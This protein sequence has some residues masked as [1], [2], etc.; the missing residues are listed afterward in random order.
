MQLTT[1]LFAVY[2]YA[3]FPLAY[4]LN[5]RAT[6]QNCHNVDRLDRTV[7]RMHPIL[8]KLSDMH[9]GKYKPPTNE[10]ITTGGSGHSRRH[11]HGDKEARDFNE[12]MQKIES[13]HE[14]L[15]HSQDKIASKRLTCQTPATGAKLLTARDLRVRGDDDDEEEEE[16]EEHD[17]SH[18][19]LDDVIEELLEAVE[20]LLSFLFGLLGGVLELIFHLL[21]GVAKIIGEMLDLD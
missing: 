14:L 15:T 11:G 4:A 8:F 19:G 7:Q 5:P 16:E 12:F 21:E 17:H 2:A 6:L 18:C 10:T 9:K 3:L 20:C 1:I 13:L